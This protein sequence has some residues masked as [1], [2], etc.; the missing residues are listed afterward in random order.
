MSDVQK[1]LNM[2]DVLG[3]QEKYQNYKAVVERTLPDGLKKE[4]IRFWAM[5]AQ[6][7]QTFINDP[8]ITNK[9]SVLNCLFNAP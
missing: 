4:S 8:K 3:S 1:I 6:M 5:F 7:A 2:V 9:L